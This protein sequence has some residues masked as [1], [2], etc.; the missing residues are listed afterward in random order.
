MEHFTFTDKSKGS[1]KVDADKKRVSV[2]GVCEFSNVFGN[3]TLIMNTNII[4]NYKFKINNLSDTIYLG[5]IR[6]DKTN[7]M[8][9]YQPFTNSGNAIALRDDGNLYS[10]NGTTISDDPYYVESV[11]DC[12]FK[13]GDDITMII[14]TM[15]NKLTFTINN[16]ALKSKTIKIDNTNN[17]RI[18]AYLY[19]S[20]E[21]GGSSTI[22]L[23]SYSC[24]VCLPEPDQKRN[25]ELHDDEN[26]RMTK[27]ENIIEKFNRIIEKKDKQI[28]ELQEQT[29]HQQEVNLDL[30]AE[31]TMLR[32]SAEQNENENNNTSC[33][34]QAAQMA[35]H[36]HQGM[37][38][39]FDQQQQEQ[40]LNSQLVPI[41]SNSIAY[42]TDYFDVPVNNNAV[43][44]CSLY[45]PYEISGVIPEKM[46]ENHV[47]S[48][49]NNNNNVQVN[50][51]DYKE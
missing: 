47:T 25:D 16:D 19:G 51:N 17:Y 9:G 26:E 24:Q 20:A 35:Y 1:V 30:Q 2:S 42:S 43:Y 15:E 27:L 31:N 45:L 7:E 40:R 49:N 33:S 41:Y 28:Q 14:N 29:Q 50:G 36:N 46:P 8:N 12:K 4:H 21:Y 10:P 39:Q 22:T 23:S 3:N 5:I 34:H 13:K 6:E 32:Q 48:S 38:D 11:I 44:D 37:F 18:A